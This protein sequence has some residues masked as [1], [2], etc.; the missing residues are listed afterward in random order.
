MKITGF[1][2][3]M[4][5]TTGKGWTSD[6]NLKLGARRRTISRIDL[7]MWPVDDHNSKRG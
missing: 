7:A 1:N 6:G 4:G 5:G 3:L 2:A